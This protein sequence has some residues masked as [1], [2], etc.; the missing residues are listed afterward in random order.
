[1]P[2]PP[3]AH[4]V[5]RF[6][7]LFQGRDAVVYLSALA[8]FMGVEIAAMGYSRCSLRRLLALSPSARNDI[9]CDTLYFFGFGK[10]FAVVGTFGIPLLLSAAYHRWVGFTLLPHIANPVAAY[11]LWFVIAEFAY[12]GYHRSMHEIACLWQTHKYH[13][14]AVEFN[15]ITGNR[16]HFLDKAM[17]ELFNLVPLT[18][19][20]IPPTMYASLR[21]GMRL[22]E[23]AQHSAVDWDYG[24]IGRWIVYGPVGHRIHHSAEREHWDRN[25]GN[26]MVIW[27]RLFGTWYAGSRVNPSVG[28][29][30]N[31]FNTGSVAKDWAIATRLFARDLA[32]GWKTGEWKTEYAREVS[33]TRRAARSQ[34]L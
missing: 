14:S 17:A 18:L 30:D 33:E 20:G 9:L 22:I 19:L 32:R 25:Y 28:V 16:V 15:L 29:S 26:L 13:H 21:L 2:V 10:V 12:Y 4:Y 24:W 5:H 23:I 3:F 11:L 6:V 27:D 7:S 34:A 1:M 31:H 8:I